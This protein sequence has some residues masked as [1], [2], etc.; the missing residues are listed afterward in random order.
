VEICDPTGAGDTFISAMAAAM[1]CDCTIEQACIIAN[2]AA[3][4]SVMT[5]GANAPTFAQIQEAL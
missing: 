2:C 3:R 4:L 1:C 5:A